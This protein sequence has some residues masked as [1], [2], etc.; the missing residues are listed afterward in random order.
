MKVARYEVPGKCEHKRPSRR[1]RYD[2]LPGRPTSPIRLFYGP[3]I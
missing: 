3:E 1:V 2:K